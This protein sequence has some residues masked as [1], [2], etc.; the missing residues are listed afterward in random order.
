MLSPDNLA[1]KGSTSISGDLLFRGTPAIKLNG[2]PI[3]AGTKDGPG[4]ATPTNYTLTLGGG[5]V[6]RYLVRHVDAIAL[7][8][9]NAPAAP[10]GTRSVTLSSSGQ[11]AGDFATL[12]DLT[13]NGGAGA[14]AIPAGNY[15]AFAANGSSGFVLGVAG[16]TE[17][18]VYNLQS[19]T[20]NGSSTL[21]VVGPVILNLA[22]GP[23]IS[24]TIGNSAHPEWLEVRVYSGGFKLNSYATCHGVVIAP[25]GTVVIG[26]YAT[27][28]GRVS[29]DG[30]TLNLNALLDEA[31][32]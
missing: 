13:L 21:Q 10:A 23:S 3:F 6:V 18:A 26:G 25:A 14:V 8:V 30:L 31:A 12:R 7:P 22:N 9:V 1:L 11:S 17:P 5:S 28:H 19:L 16:A 32:P 29:S 24:G 20:L 15:G 2:S 4:S 27:L